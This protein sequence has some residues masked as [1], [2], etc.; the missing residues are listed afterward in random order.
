MDALDSSVEKIMKSN[1]R[2]KHRE[3]EIIFD[4]YSNMM[5]ELIIQSEAMFTKDEDNTE[6]DNNISSP[7]GETASKTLDKLQVFKSVEATLNNI[8]NRMV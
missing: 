3:L 8:I 1:T 5:I 6:P 4:E 2:D 7:Y